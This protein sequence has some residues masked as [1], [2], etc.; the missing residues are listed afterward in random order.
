MFSY[1]VSNVHLL[2]PSDPIQTID[3]YAR[4]KND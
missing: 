3:I 1:D 4:V 2:D